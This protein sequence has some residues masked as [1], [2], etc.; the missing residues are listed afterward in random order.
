MMKES[1]MHVEFTSRAERWTIP[2]AAQSPEFLTRQNEIRTQA[3][4]VERAGFERF[5][6][7]DP[8]GLPD[9]GQLASFILHN[10]ASLGVIV[11]HCAGIVAPTVAAQQFATLDQLSG[12]RLTIQ[13]VAGQCDLDHEAA[14]ARTDEYLV[15]LK[16]LWANDKPFDHEGPFYSIRNGHAGAKPFGRAQVPLMLGG[17]SGTAIKVAARH[18]E[19]F[20]LPAGS[21]TETRQIVSRVQAAAAHHGRADKIRYS[22]PVQPIVAATRAEA[23]AR[24]EQLPAA[25]EAT[26][27]V[28]TAEQVARALNDYRALGVSAFVLHDLAQPRDIETFVREVAPRVRGRMEGAGEFRATG[29]FLSSPR[30]RVSYYA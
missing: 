14:F 6:I 21:I 8:L 10:T 18:A 2:Q 1:A 4:A 17:A 19:I 26:R 7:A 23:L 29:V 12:G 27:L 24:A 30:T 13:V 25:T 28:G 9:N 15:L 16:R 5:L 11:S 22:A 20:A 3:R